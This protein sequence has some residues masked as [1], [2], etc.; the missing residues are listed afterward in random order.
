MILQIFVHIKDRERFAVEAGEKHI[1]HEKDVQRLRL[2]TLYTIRNVLVI[3]GESI[4]REVC[5]I[6]LIIIFDDPLQRI[7]A[8]LV[9][10][11]RIFILSI[12]KD[13]GNI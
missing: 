4:S 3:G 11:L 13:T 5:T 6:H 8:M 9:F 1:D 2:L 7:T 12:R 10:S